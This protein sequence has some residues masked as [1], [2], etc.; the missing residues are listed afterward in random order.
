MSEKLSQKDLR[1]AEA[2][3]IKPV[4]NLPTATP[5]STSVESVDIDSLELPDLGADLAIMTQMAMEAYE[6][7]K[8]I[9]ESSED[10]LDERSKATSQ[11]TAAAQLATAINAMDKVARLK[12]RIIE[13][14]KNLNDGNEEDE[15]TLTREEL[16][17]LIKQAGGETKQ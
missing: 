12:L 6:Q 17:E 14:K 1:I 2:L 7:S 15:K 16:M 9:A 3:D 4:E 11:S 5:S 13:M 8:A 10:M